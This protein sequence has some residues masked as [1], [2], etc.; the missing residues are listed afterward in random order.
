MTDSEGGIVESVPRTVSISPELIAST[1]I[2][3]NAVWKYFDG[4]LNLASAWKEPGYSDAAWASGPARLG[5]GSDGEITTV[6]YGANGNSK[7]ITT[8]FRR[9][10][11]VPP[12]VVYTN[13]QFGL[14]RDDGAVVWL[15]GIELFRSNMPGGAIGYTTPAS[16]AVSG[17]DEVTFFPTLVPAANLLAGS[18]LIAVEVHQS[19]WNQL[20]P[21]FDLEV[22]GQGYVDPTAAPSL[23]LTLDDGWIEVSWP[24]TAVGWQLYHASEPQAPPA[25]WSPVDATPVTVSAARS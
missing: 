8:Y 11:E 1:F 10:F 4:G 19:Q 22:I 21:R 16:S 7:Y 12:G 20:R 14:Q 25:A 5:Y 23:E 24:A 15:N 13:L 6:S 3:R 2:P 9:A 18:H 17:T